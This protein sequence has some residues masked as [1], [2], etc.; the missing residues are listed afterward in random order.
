M[1]CLLACAAQDED[2]ERARQAAL[3][4]LRALRGELE[5]ADTRARRKHLQLAV[6]EKLAQFLVMPPWSGEPEEQRS[7]LEQLFELHEALARPAEELDQVLSAILALE[8]LDENMARRLDWERQRR[9]FR[10]GQPAPVWELTPLLGGEPTGLKNFEGRCVLL[11]FW[12]TSDA[13]HKTLVE[14][15]IPIQL[16]R[17]AGQLQVVGVSTLAGDSLQAQQE[18]ART[19]QLPWLLLSDPEGT[20]ER[21]Y[22]TLGLR[23]YL[24]AI[25]EQGNLLGVGRGWEGLGEIE[26]ALVDHL[27]AER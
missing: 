7:W 14:S 23:P 20:T 10:A 8:G 26:R 13:S 4:E 9:L 18:F 21:S 17:F 6:F 25:D 27:E 2:P 19:L 11:Y 22:F 15:W 12:Q 24:C 1:L 5:Q 3:D 16:E